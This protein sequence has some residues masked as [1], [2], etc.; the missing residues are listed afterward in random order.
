MNAI[1]IEN[2]S[3]RYPDGTEALKD[4]S[5]TLQGRRKLALL[6][7]NGSGKSTL[8]AHLNG[9]IPAQTGLVRIFELPVTN[10]N[11]RLVRQKV[12]ILFDNP[13]NQLFSATVFDD[14]AFG[15]FNMGCPDPEIRQRTDEALHRVGLDTLRDRPPQNLSLGQK[16][17]A[18]IA[19]LLAMSPELLVMDEPFSGLDPGSIAEFLAILDVLY[20]NEV[21]QVLSTHDVDRAYAWA[22]EVAILKD[23]RLLASGPWEL[24]HDPALM[25]ESE[26]RLPTLVQLFERTGHRPRNLEQARIAMGQ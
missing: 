13:D 1:E 25:R 24:L 10:R 9:L 23:G 15:P 4:V 16:K 3:Y 11:L 7:S 2:L 26:L 14:V 17:K 5:L 22:D 8:L 6:G 20:E 12:A 18:A 21:T 19:G